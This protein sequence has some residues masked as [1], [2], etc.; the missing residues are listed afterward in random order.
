MKKYLIL[1][2][3]LLISAMSFSQKLVSVEFKSKISKDLAQSLVTLL[4]L[5]TQVSNGVDIYKVRYLT[6]GSDMRPDTA[7]GLMMLPDVINGPLPIMC[8]QHGT[9]QGRSDVPSNLMG[10]Y[11]LGGLFS[12]LGMVSTAADF[13]GMGDSRGFHPYVNA[14]TEGTAG[15]DL[16][17]AVKS[18]LETNKIATNG[19]LFI[20]GYSQ[21]GHAAMA[22]HKLIQD[23][24]GQ[25]YKVT[26]SLPMSGPYSISGVMRDLAFT[27]DPYFF[28]SYLVY[29]TLGMKQIDPTLYNDISEVFR[30]QFL[31][32]IRAFEQ[33]GEGVGKLN[34]DIVSILQRDFGKSI[35]KFLYKDSML[36]VIQT[37][38]NH[39]FNKALRDNDLFNWKPD[40]PVFMLYCKSDDQ[41]PFRNSV[42]AD[43]VMNALGAKNV[44]S[45]DV[46]NGQQ[47]T[48]SGCVVPA[49]AIG[50]PWIMSFV[51]KTV[52]VREIDAEFA[53]LQIFPNP[54]SEY[55]RIT[56]VKDRIRIELIDIQA[57]SLLIKELDDDATVL[58]L[59][60]LSDGLYFL[61][62]SNKEGKFHSFKLVIQH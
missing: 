35:P 51:D 17:T 33:T 5:S 31:S 56:N 46:S 32:I 48:H 22:A 18:Y 42:I 47:F 10:G 4:G 8:Y 61:R 60:G 44:K 14:E 58:S 40:A 54:A 21:G 1:I 6:L 15:V 20:S 9:T 45:M 23:S 38:A 36:N 39:A 27:D 55:L 16:I 49:L 19:Q 13:L 7:S 50:V 34:Q 29:T 53:Q 37:Q 59:D 43:S 25:T 28:P 26:A 2:G 24:Y 12:A 57:R 3:A 11:E 62:V 30:P 41:V 52:P